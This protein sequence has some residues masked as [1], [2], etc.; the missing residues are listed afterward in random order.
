MSVLD[1]APNFQSLSVA[2][3]IEAR[4]LYHFHLMNKANVIGTAIGLYLIRKKEARPE[5]DKPIVPMTYARTLANSEVRDYSWPCILVFVRE[6]IAEEQF[7]RD[8][9]AAPTTIVPSTIYMPDGRTVPVCV[10]QADE[11][12]QQEDATVR[13]TGWPNSVFGGGM[14]L[15]VN[16]QQQEHFGSVGCLVTDG[17]LTYALTSRHVCG[18]AGTPVSSLL[19]E[20]ARVIGK[21]SSKQ[22][23]RKLFSQVYPE[24]SGRKSYVNLDV[25][26][27]ALDDINAWT[28]NVFRL[29][30]V[31]HLAD[32]YEQ[33]LTLRLID[34]P[35][36]AYGAASGLLRGKIK[37][38]FYR[39]RSVGGYDY[40]GDFLI[41]PDS[42]SPSTQPGDS[43]T[44][45]HLDVAP[46]T[47][48]QASTPLGKTDLHP[49]AIEWG[50]QTFGDGD[51]RTTFAVATSLSNVCKLLD[52]E[53]VT[54]LNSGV[55]GYWGRVGHYT[56]GTFAIELLRKSQHPASDKLVTLLSANISNISFDIDALRDD[57]IDK[58]NPQ[59]DFTHLADVPDDVWK[60][61]PE[62]KKKGV[63]G[64]RDIRGTEHGT[65]GPE[66]PNH[67][68]DI[69]IPYNPGGGFNPAAPSLRQR[70][71]DDAS[72]LTV[73]AWAKFYIWR[74][75]H[76]AAI[77][78]GQG[79]GDEAAND[80]AKGDSFKNGLLP[81]RVWQIY[82]QLTQFA[83]K[84]D[85]ERF[86]AAAG[87]LAH[88]VGDASQPLHG[89][90]YADGDPSRK[91]TRQHPQTGKTETVNYAAGVHSAYETAMVTDKKAEL[92]QLFGTHVSG[93]GHG[94]PL[95]KTGK[96]AA[97]V[98]IRL[99]DDVAKV[100]PP[101]EICK[102]YQD[103]VGSHPSAT[104]AM[105]NEM[106][107]KLGPR[108]VDVMV[109]GARYLAM[110]WESAWVNGQGAAV[111]AGTLQEIDRE[112]LK[113]LYRDRTFLESLTLENIGA[114]LLS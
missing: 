105:R 40:V 11:V 67:Y 66:H 4:D 53:L 79:A 49:L 55:H 1:P 34:Q 59:E 68:A 18:E 38:L 108:T 56:I 64:G 5:P 103:L 107:T 52:V 71:L 57:D 90:T 60:H 28:K 47:S 91:V 54:D 39:Y 37:A 48:G 27:V 97:R 74:A 22:L 109:L 94:L 13:I 43:G 9:A 41:A 111:Q 63:K 19:R 31:G 82:N 32:M 6:W 104:K 99:M 113:A 80:S 45:W 76:A 96:D 7:G 87:I 93:A 110:I 8:G 101:L 2:D 100:L 86:V 35:V 62:D 23:T 46:K 42:G 15:S 69:D 25:G 51:V 24:F 65:T 26:L 14:P 95:V 98:I 30:P 20:G 78:G 85:M 17:H 114:Q 12:L 83:S 50:G 29:P 3:L 61:L 112:R 88:Y 102:T 92:L 70:C 77:Q 10:V 33:S 75:Q 84:G 106:W 81:F 73:E 58:L 89:S 21:A 16:I 36:V 72:F 44:I